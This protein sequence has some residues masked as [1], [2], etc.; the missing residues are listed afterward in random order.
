MKRYSN[1]K[2]RMIKQKISGLILML[3]GV[4]P[5][6]IFKDITDLTY[7]VAF[8]IGKK[9]V[10][11]S[12]EDSANESNIVG[13]KINH[14]YSKSLEFENDFRWFT[15]NYLTDKIEYFSLLRPLNELQIMKIF[16]KYPLQ[17]VF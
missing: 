2:K 16:T 17:E 14:Q 3:I 1:R 11:L 5:S 10:A 9:Y 12:N 7:L 15:K 4:I 13:E 6:I 8:L